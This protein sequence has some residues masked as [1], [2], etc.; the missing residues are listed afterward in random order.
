MSDFSAADH[1]WMARALQL[2]ERGRWTA[3]PNP[4]VGCVLVRDGVCLGEAWHV[5]AGEPHAEVL[6]LRAAG[7]DTAGATAYV[8][9]EPCSH[10]GRTPPCADALIE[11]GIARVVAGASDPNP[12]VSGCGLDRL[13]ASGVAVAVGLM[14][15]ESERLNAGFFR[16]MRVGRPYVRAKLAASV[17]GRTAMA[18]GE[19][20]WI[21][22]AD[23][24]RDVHRWRAGSGA[25][26]TGVDTV[27]ADDPALTVRDV[28]GDFV[29]PRRIVVDTDLRTPPDAGLLADERGVVLVHGGTMPA[30]EADRIH[31]GAE[32]WQVALGADGH[33]SPKAVLEALASAD[34]NEVWLEAGSRLAGAW[35][36][37]G[38]VDELMIYVAPHVMGHQGQPLLTLPGLD[39]MS[40]RIALKWLDTRRVGHDLRLTMAMRDDAEEG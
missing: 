14:A 28:D 30:R 18:S 34:I 10:Y 31:A 7:D 23:A 5:R 2:A 40:D 36:Q 27:I 35:L 22:G 12:R 16:R 24:R 11:A 26:V 17:D 19:S 37:A 29:A 32:L 20:R 21:T 1:A 9:L 3:D 39:A 8:T 38:L 6:A 33:V 4:R 25:I 13:R 15:A